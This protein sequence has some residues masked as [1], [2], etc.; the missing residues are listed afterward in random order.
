MK[1]M[2]KRKK[3]F[4]HRRY[5]RNTSKIITYN[6]CTY[7][8][9]NMEVKSKKKPFLIDNKTKGLF[10]VQ[11]SM[12]REGIDSHNTFT[13]AINWSNVRLIMMMY[14]MAVWELRQIDY[15]LSFPQALIDSDIYLHLPAGFHIDGEDENETYFLKLK[16]NLYGKRQA[17]AN[18]FD[19]LKTGLKD[20]G[21]K[22]NKI[23]PFLFVRNDCI[24]ICY[25]D[26]CCIWSEDKQTSYA[27][28]KI[29]SNTFK[30]TDKGNVKSYLGMNQI[31]SINII[32][33]VSM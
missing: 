28:L 19:I 26:D 21:F 32:W 5:L 22:Q 27:L 2:E 8:M 11:S 13:P 14:E 17:E 9:I 7:N 31:H 23:Y 30:L 16:K 10:C 18:W 3:I 20:E 29:L 33:L 6:L 1:S 25:V 4:D 12:K 15:V 24:V